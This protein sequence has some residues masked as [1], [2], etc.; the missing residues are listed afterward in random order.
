MGQI[1]RFATRTIKDVPLTFENETGERVTENF[2]V[3]Y[4]SYSTKAHE[5]FQTLQQGD[6]GRVPF[7]VALSHMVER[8]ID[9]D[10]EPL[11]GD[12]GNP[13]DMSNGFFDW[14][15]LEEAR[16]LYE[17]IDADIFPRKASP[18]DGD[19]GSK[20]AASEA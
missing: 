6:D 19:S 20:A 3:V 2:T 7:S 4:R 5:E 8:I 15:P 12:D 13:A 1:R 11:T 16:D 10:G 9:K 17:R 14:I 18:A